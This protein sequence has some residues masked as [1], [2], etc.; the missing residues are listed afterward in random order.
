[1]GRCGSPLRRNKSETE[2]FFVRPFFDIFQ[3]EKI[4]KTNKHK[5]DNCQTQ[6]S[7]TRYILLRNNIKTYKHA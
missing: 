3:G 1:M 7:R 4:H 6:K 5:I 2:L